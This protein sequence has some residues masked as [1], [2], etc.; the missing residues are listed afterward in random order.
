MSDVYAR[1]AAMLDG[2]TGRQ[3][4]FA[5]GGWLFGDVL[6]AGHGELRLACGGL[7]LTQGDVK[8]DRGLG[9][10]GTE[11]E[12]EGDELRAGDRVLV[13]VTADGQEYYVLKK[14]VFV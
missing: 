4:A 5:P 13:L 11:E 7:S 3:G 14:A 9:D 10:T 1:L 8:V 12:G 2:G 6:E